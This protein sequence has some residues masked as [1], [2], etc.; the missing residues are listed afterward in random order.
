MNIMIN[1]QVIYRHDSVVVNAV[2]RHDYF[3]MMK[4]QDGTFLPFY[5][6]GL[7]LQALSRLIRCFYKNN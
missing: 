4:R 6:L 5:F 1:A 2:V 3:C 7:T